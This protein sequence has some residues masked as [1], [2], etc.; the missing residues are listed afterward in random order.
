MKTDRKGVGKLERE[1][2][3]N[4]R[5][6]GHEKGRNGRREGEGEGED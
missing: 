6:S 2:K 3:G 1:R 5:E 4:E